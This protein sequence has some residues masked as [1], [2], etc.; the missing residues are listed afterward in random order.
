MSVRDLLSPFSA[1]KNLLREP[2]SIA[3]PL[4]R[5]AAERYRGFHQNDI[6]KCI[7]CGTCEAICQKWGYRYGSVEQ[8]ETMAGDSGCGLKL[9]MVAAAGAPSVSISV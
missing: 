2:V 6:D 8:I 4:N 7:G 1:W 5:P 9:T 3:D